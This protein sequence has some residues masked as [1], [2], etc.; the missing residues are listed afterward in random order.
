MIRETDYIQQLAN[1]MKKNL[2]KGYPI[3]TLRFAL[4]NQGYSRSA[5]YRATKIAN[6]QLAKSLPKLKE[7]PVIRIIPN[8]DLESNK[9]KKK[10]FFSR[11]K[12]K[13]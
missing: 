5:V 6:E 1:Y 12:N 13:K 10:G 2:S 3:D 9:K 11:F 4:L 7:K 8:P